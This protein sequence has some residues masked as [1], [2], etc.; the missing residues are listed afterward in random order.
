MNRLRFLMVVLLLLGTAMLIHVRGDSD[1]IPFSQPLAQFPTAIDGMTS[2][3][4]PIDQETRDVLGHGDFLSRDYARAG[5]PMPINLFIGYFPSQRTGSSVHSPKNCLPGSGW[6]FDSSRYVDLRDAAGKAHRVGEYIISDGQSRDFVIY[7]YQ[8]RGRSEADEY[9][10]LLYSI[11][12]AIR[13]RRSDG[14]LVRV[15]TP[16]GAQEEASVAQARA[17]QFA[18][19]LAPQLKPFIPD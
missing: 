19:L 6:V 5:L 11:I 9:W 10:A 1:R 2:T 18:A 13:L 8:E 4:L 14:A 3:D 16:I 17:E 12:D 15:I 7:W